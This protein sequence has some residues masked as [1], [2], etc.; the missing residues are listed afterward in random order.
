MQVSRLHYDLPS[1][2]IAQQ[3]AEPRDHAQLMVVHRNSGLIEHRRFFEIGQYL[4]AGD[5]LVVNDTRVIPARFFARRASGGRIEGLFLHAESETHWRVLLKPSLRLKV[6]ERLELEST[7][8]ISQSLKIEAKL[9]RGEWVVRPEPAVDFLDFLA[10]HGLTPL[11]PYMKR[12][13]APDPSDRERYQTV[14]AAAPGAVAAPTAG[15]HFTDALLDALLAAGIRRVALTLHVGLG[16]FS[17]VTVA[18][19]R[20]HPMHAEWYRV[21]AAAAKEIA[22]LRLGGGRVV[23]V[24]TTSARTLECLPRLGGRE[25]QTVESSGATGWTQL[26]IL[27]P[28][29]FRNVDALVTNFHLPGSTLLAMVMALAGEELIRLAYAEAIQRKYRFFS[30][31]DAMLIL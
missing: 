22:E 17:P 30:Y 20:E 3:P 10:A 1:E 16:T 14:Y 23:A 4:H 18:D 7:R 12:A 2:R 28:Y 26:L 19:L 24:G 5:G 31:G 9:E 6:G 27:P 15:L 13:A 8:A 29:E 25:G 11:P 21:E